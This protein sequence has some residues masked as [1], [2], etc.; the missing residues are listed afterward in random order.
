[1]QC[2]GHVKLGN[3]IRQKYICARHV[4]TIFYIFKWLTNFLSIH[5]KNEV[6]SDF[7]YQTNIWIDT[8]KVSMWVSRLNKNTLIIN[9][10]LK[11]I[12]IGLHNYMWEWFALLPYHCLDING[13]IYTWLSVNVNDLHVH[14]YTK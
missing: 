11:F 8:L 1:M 4:D 14:A 6:Q 5:L 2:N 10:C 13:I 12:Y 3:Y 7:Q 9:T